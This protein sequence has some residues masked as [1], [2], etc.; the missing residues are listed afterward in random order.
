M[1][2]KDWPYPCSLDIKI[3]CVGYIY[4]KYIEEELDEEKRL[5]SVGDHARKIC[6]DTN[7]HG[8]CLVCNLSDLDRK[9]MFYHILEILK[10]E[11]VC[12]HYKSLHFRK[13]IEKPL[14]N[15]CIFNMTSIT[16]LE[17]RYRIEY[18]NGILISTSLVKVR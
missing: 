17:C 16:C 15:H 5:I 12:D 18:E 6:A 3:R 11:Y 7:F 8:S 14:K 13:K 4:E 10:K 2:D 1:S 9:A